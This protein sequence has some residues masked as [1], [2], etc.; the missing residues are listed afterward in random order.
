MQTS[1]FS[2]AY[3]VYHLQQLLID[4]LAIGPVGGVLT[5]TVDIKA[6]AC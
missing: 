2:I 6:L 5:H 3:Q 1:A 4:V